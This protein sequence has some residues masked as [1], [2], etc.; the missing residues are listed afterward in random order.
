MW[1]FILLWSWLMAGNGP[2][3][4]V[5]SCGETSA[6]QQVTANGQILGSI[7][8]TPIEAPADCYGIGKFRNGSYWVATE[9][10]FY[11]LSPDL[12]RQRGG[13][14][15]VETIAGASGRHLYRIRRGEKASRRP[16]EHKAV[17]EEIDPKTWA[18]TRSWTLPGTYRAYGRGNLA[19]D[20]AES[21]AYYTRE[22]SSG[23]VHRHD[24]KADVALPDLI[25]RTVPTGGLIVLPDQTVVVGYTDG[26]Q[27]LSPT[28]AHL[29]T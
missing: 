15:A 7:P 27:A 8:N 1:A 3:T 16:L 14:V 13:V 25:S 5:F 11:T 26:V 6:W 2:T 18:I 12:K 20:L 29:R 19:V 24:L 21:V 4:L 23:T 10:H 22:K 17:L 9:H 28:G